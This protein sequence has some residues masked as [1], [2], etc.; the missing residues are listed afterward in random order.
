MK[1]V[2]RCTLCLTLAACMMTPNM[3]PVAIQVTARPSRFVGDTLI[4]AVQS[5][6]PAVRSAMAATMRTAFPAA[7]VWESLVDTL[8]SPR[9]VLITATLVRYGPSWGGARG[10]TGHTGIDVFVY[11]H[12]VFPGNRFV[13]LIL[14]RLDRDFRIEKSGRPNDLLDHKRRA[15]CVHVEFLRSFVR[16]RNAHFSVGCW[17]LSACSRFIG[18]ER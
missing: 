10:W 17:T 8:S 13:D 9:R 5:A 1:T 14:K 4:L 11:D 2:L 16:S 18:V 12:R 3:N 7:V 6:M 15:G